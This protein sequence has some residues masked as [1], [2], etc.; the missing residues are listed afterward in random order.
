MGRGAGAR[1]KTMARAEI[2]DPAAGAQA[3]ARALRQPVGDAVEEHLAGVRDRRSR[4]RLQRNP[5]QRRHLSAARSVYD[6]SPDLLRDPV[7]GDT[8]WTP[9]RARPDL[10]Q[11]VI[12]GVDSL[13]RSQIR[14]D[15]IPPTRNGLSRS[16]QW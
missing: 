16:R 4:P 14:I 10:R 12:Q 6:R 13:A 11:G 3:D 8:R 2:G 7:S 15:T 1:T 5:D 9:A